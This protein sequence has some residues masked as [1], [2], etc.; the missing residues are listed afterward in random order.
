MSSQV[1]QAMLWVALWILLAT[2]TRV[3]H[4]TILIAASATACLEL[5][6][7]S[8]VYLNHSV[9]VPK[10]LATR[11]LFRYAAAL[12]LSLSILTMAAVFAIQLL[13][14]I[15]WRPDARRFGL[16]VNI[17]SDFAWI[18]LHVLAAALFYGAW[19]RW[20]GVPRR[21]RCPSFRESSS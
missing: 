11:R 19:R 16:W 1:L 13:Y 3:F 20:F 21:R 4:P 18:A 6:S 2:A 7:L 5:A 17:E 15:F 8:A 9:L 14:D 10:F 12:L